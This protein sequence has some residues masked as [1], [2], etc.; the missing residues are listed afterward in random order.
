MLQAAGID[1]PPVDERA[2]RALCIVELVAMVLVRDPGVEPRGIRV[3]QD[4]LVLVTPA[5]VDLLS[6]ISR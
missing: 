1:A 4:E 3:C 5:Y 6:P 2:I